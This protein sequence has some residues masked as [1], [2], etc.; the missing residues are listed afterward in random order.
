MLAEFN[1]VLQRST[2]EQ[3]LHT[4]SLTEELCEPLKTEDYVVQSS[5]DVSPP[6]WHLGHTTW[7]FEHFVLQRHIRD[8]QPFNQTY[9]YLFN[10]YYE[11]AGTFFPKNLR[12]ILSRPTVEEV[13]EYRRHINKLVENLLTE[14]D[15]QELSGL[16][17]LGINHE[18]QHQELLLMDV[19][20]NF[21]SNPLIP[22]YSETEP[23]AR[24][25]VT[26]HNWVTIE[27][28]MYLIGHNGPGFAF[29]NET[30][31]HKV[32]LNSFKVSDSLVTNSEFLDFIS[33][34]GYEKPELW[35]SD[36]WS[37][38]RE[39]KINCPLYWRQDRDDWKVFSLSGLRDMVPSEPVSHVSFFEAD[40]FARWM[41]KRLPTEQ[42]WEVA[43]RKA[44]QDSGNFLETHNFHPRPLTSSNGLDQ[45]FGDL[46]EWTSSSYLPYPKFVPLAGSLGEYNGKFMNGQRVLRGGSCVTPKTHIRATYRNFFQPEKRWEFSGIRLVEDLNE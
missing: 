41:G 7:F 27:G 6:K 4:R 31:S 23:V 24:T 12:G 9:G 32:Y 11:T 44:H 8:Y 16:V 18:Q 29:D 10:S 17:T 5:Y 34:G 26:A 21:W 39:R 30:P 28:G 33:A 2:L 25:V 15:S 20:H 42:E 36:G 38:V 3:F 37:W 1:S 43:S 40:A 46:W 45:M 35:L 22:N 14:N 19:K 13:R